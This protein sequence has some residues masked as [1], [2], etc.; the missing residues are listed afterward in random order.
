MINFI[1]NIKNPRLVTWIRFGV[2]Q[3]R[4]N[5]LDKNLNEKINLENEECKS[6]Y[7]SSKYK[8]VLK[9]LIK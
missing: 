4:H 3:G 9:Y 5:I 1:K 6:I 2:R 7:E 8:E